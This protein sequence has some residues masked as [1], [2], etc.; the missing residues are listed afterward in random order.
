STGLLDPSPVRQTTVMNQSFYAR[1][2]WWIIAGAALLIPPALWGVRETFRNANNN[3]SQW[4]P[5]DYK[6]TRV[7]QE[8]RDAFGSDDFAL[9]S[10]D[11]CTLDDERL[12]KLARRLVP[13]PGAAHAGNGSEWFKE[14]ITGPRALEKLTGEPFALARSEALERLVGTLVGP[15]GRT[16]CAVVILSDKGDSDRTGALAAIRQMAA[17][18]GLDPEELRLGG[19]AVINAAIDIE[20]Q[21]AISKWVGLAW[22]SALVFAWLSLRQFRLVVMVFAVSV[23]AATLGTGL[24]HYTGG[25]MN[26]LLVLVPVLLCV[27]TVSG[28]VHLSNYYRDTIR[29]FGASGAPLRAMA[30]G[31]TPC[32]L[33]AI[34]TA[35]GLGSLYVSH[36]IPV[37]SFGLY[38]ATGMLLS[39]GI[40]FLLLPTLMEKWPLPAPSGA[41]ASANPAADRRARLLGDVAGAIIRHHRWV[42]TICMAILIALGFGAAFLKTAIQPGRFFPADSEWIV[43][44][45]WLA[46]HLGPMVTVEVV[47]SIDREDPMTMLERMELVSEVTQT[48]HDMEE[49][50]GTISAAT[51][52][53][54]LESQKTE[55]DGRP[56]RLSVREKARR[57]STN[58]RL[59]ANRDFFVKQRYLHDDGEQER[60]RITS[61]VKGGRDADYDEVLLHIEDEVDGFLNRRVAPPST[62]TAVYTGSAPLVFVAQKE[63]LRGLVRSF[64]LAFA[65]I[66]VLMVLL[67]R[68]ASA[69]A[70][71]MI[72]N[73]FPALTTFG[74]MGW[75]A[76][77]VDV[78]AMMTAS[79]ALGIAVDDTLHF[80][81]WFRRGMLHGDTRTEAI[82]EAYQR[83]APAMTQ[84]TLIAAPALLVFFL[85]SFQP[86]SQFG[87]LMFILLLAALV[88]DLIFLPALLATRFGECFY[89]KSQSVD[90]GRGVKGKGRGVKG[91]GR[92][93][94]CKGR[95]VKSKGRGVKGKR[96][97][98]RGKG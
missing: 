36:I 20:S 85:S 73:V 27:L 41:S 43:D 11:D 93:V 54:R 37:K 69:G 97:G 13:T 66:A 15:D 84:T 74:L 64:G 90:E 72:P 7:Y 86:V 25:T 95:G 45:R 83:C 91:K 8:F 46:S 75:M 1:R 81:T 89:R 56:K 24:I 10:W 3:V 39:L 59:E 28:A 96:R 57:V 53:P 18:C 14:V 60:W 12:E 87:L 9:V 62:V 33:S 23:Y 79:V 40:L 35:L 32:A 88:G 22:L 38:S 51:F 19:D 48:I 52:G 70:L 65:L 71:A 92:G 31:W 98:M 26:L 58:A 67:L 49:V 82:V 6:E 55:P 80:L 63:L 44:S 2:A 16:T 68:S 61:R 34:T 5:E 47:L 17:E 76:R 77:P 4:L 29:E 78:G 94:K 21:A 50:G 42:V 30:S